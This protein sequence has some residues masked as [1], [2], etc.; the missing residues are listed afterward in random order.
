MGK[1]ANRRTA[2][3]GGGGGGSNG[4][5]TGGFTA[6]TPGLEDV[7]FA[8]GTPE[9]AAKYEKNMEH[10]TEHLGVQPCKG[11]SELTQA[12]E[13]MENAVYEEPEEPIRL[14]YANASK[15]K[16]TLKPNKDDG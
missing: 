7:I 11:I 13:R 6:P 15:T 5:A 8:G 10:L 4:S 16:T 9:A 3:T 1:S 12:I 14:Y 2:S